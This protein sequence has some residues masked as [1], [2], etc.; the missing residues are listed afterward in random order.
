MQPRSASPGDDVLRA[1][2][3]L[4]QLV[5]DYREAPL[6]AVLMP[7][8]HKLNAVPLHD[9][10][11]SFSGDRADRI[12]AM[13]SGGIRRMVK[14]DDFPILAGV[15]QVAL[16][17]RE[18][19]V[20]GSALQQVRVDRSEVNVAPIVRI[21]APEIGRVDPAIGHRVDGQVRRCRVHHV[22]V[23]AGGRKERKAFH[24]RSV[25]PEV[26]GIVLREA[27]LRIGEVTRMERES[28]AG[29]GAHQRR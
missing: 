24:Q 10:V 7:A 11:D 3:L 20:G 23:I 5:F 9:R 27:P 6:I 17:P 18:H 8:Q 29:F 22:I 16:Q 4:D 14:V 13:V 19:S 21:V 25:Q 2:S 15:P 12:F 26:G 1:Q 28:D